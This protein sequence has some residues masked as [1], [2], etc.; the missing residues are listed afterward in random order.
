M[1]L[2]IDF[3]P[4]KEAALPANFPEPGPVGV[5]MQKT[6]P[7]YRLARAQGG[8][9]FWQLFQHIQRENIPMTAPVEMARN[10]AGQTSMGFMYESTQQGVLGP[11]TANAAVTVTDIPPHQVLSM[12]VRGQRQQETLVLRA[13]LS[14]VGQNSMALLYQIVGGCMASARRWC[15]HRVNILKC[16]FI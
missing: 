1:V 4:V 15:Q 10:E 11:D 14:A 5:V 13:L 8:G 6:Y 16:K 3:V 7:T 2:D 12:T 9:A